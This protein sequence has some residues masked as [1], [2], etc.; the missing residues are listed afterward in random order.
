MAAGLKT[1]QLLSEPGF[2]DKLAVNPKIV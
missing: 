2:H 1:L